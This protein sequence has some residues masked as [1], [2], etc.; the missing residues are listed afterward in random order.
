M[1]PIIAIVGRPNVG[2]STFFNRLVGQRKAIVEDEPGVTRDRNYAEASYEDH[3]F[4]LIDT[5][6]FEPTSSDRIQQQIR[7]QVEVAI[8]EADLILFLMDGKE[9]LNP[10]DEEVA[11][12]LRKVSKPVFYVVNKIDGEKQ[13]GSVM[14]FY[15]LG[16]SPLYSV[17]AEH[18]RGMGDLMDEVIKVLPAGSPEAERIEEGIRVAIVGR[19][20]VGKSSLLNKLIGRPRAIVDS[21][22]GT[23]RDTLD[24]PLL[25]EGRK[26]V[27]IDTAGIRR[28]SKVTE[29]VEKYSAIKALKSLERCDVALVLIDGFEG[30]TEQ[31]ARI[32]QFAEES[33]RALILV[34]NKWDLVQKETRTMEEYKERIRREMKTLDYVP[35]LFIS[36][37]TGQRVSR[38]FQTIDE[39]MTQHRKRITTG[40]L[41]NWLRDALQNYPPPA[42]HNRPLKLLFISQVSTAPPTFVL[43]VNEPLGLAESYQRYLLRRLREKYGFTGTPL[44]L[45]LRKRKKEKAEGR[46]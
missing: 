23:T 17:S 43:F 13:E 31:D 14:D 15:R 5:G 3:S 24:T 9:G 11:G 16:V 30:L 34:V 7:E 27:F 4:I 10:T 32:S 18:G 22:P 38:L 20:N 46:G 36:A 29:R 19:P 40:E 21:T 28:K 39:V 26:Y 1:K 45:H 6:G 37:S 2:K 44:R 12:Y 33:G 8:Q 25:R 41:N 35:T 42:F